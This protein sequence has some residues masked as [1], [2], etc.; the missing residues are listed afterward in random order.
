MDALLEFLVGLLN[1]AL[2]LLFWNVSLLK[3][4]GDELKGWL[5]RCRDNNIFVRV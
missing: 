3:N 4:F 1:K 5:I 2:F